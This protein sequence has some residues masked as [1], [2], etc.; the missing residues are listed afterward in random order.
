MSEQ[1]VCS[2]CFKQPGRRMVQFM[3]SEGKSIYIHG[4]HR[5]STIFRAGIRLNVTRRHSKKAFV[6]QL[7]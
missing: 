3:N 7:A 5:T 2:V 6:M 1:P 4:H